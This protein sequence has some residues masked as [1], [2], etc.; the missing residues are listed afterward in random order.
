MPCPAWSPGRQEPCQ[1]SLGQCRRRGD[2]V[3][4]LGERVVVR[5]TEDLRQPLSVSACPSTTRRAG[6][7]LRALERVS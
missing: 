7:F 6:R 2:D 5:G 4:T 1:R 3:A